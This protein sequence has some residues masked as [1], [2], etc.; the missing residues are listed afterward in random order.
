MSG[1]Y[2]PLIGKVEFK[3]EI[4]LLG[5]KAQVD[6]TMRK[7]LLYRATHTSE[8]ALL[9]PLAGYHKIHCHVFDSF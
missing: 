8:T 2:R 7:N 4:I 1:H 3:P 9:F 6:E 5:E